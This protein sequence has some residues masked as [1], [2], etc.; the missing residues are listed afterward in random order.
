[1]QIL[2]LCLLR[3]IREFCV[4]AV[5][6]VVSTLT[7]TVGVS[8]PPYRRIPPLPAIGP[9]CAACLP[10]GG[11]LDACVA[12]TLDTVLPAVGTIPF[13]E[14]ACGT[15]LAFCAPA[16][17]LPACLPLGAAGTLCLP[18]GAC[19]CL[20]AVSLEHYCHSAWPFT[21]ILPA[22]RCLRFLPFCR[23]VLPVCLQERFPACLPYW[24]TLGTCTCHIL[25]AATWEVGLFH[26]PRSA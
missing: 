26:E 12:T 3:R 5:S 21:G 23:F 25:P 18:V 22:C 4:T 11:F 6:T 7:D 13:G 2:L 19:R 14:P 9:A 17:C 24:N 16:L 1:M 20:P 8:F 10:A 15:C